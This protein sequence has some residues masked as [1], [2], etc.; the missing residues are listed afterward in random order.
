MWIVSVRVYVI[1]SWLDRWTWVDLAAESKSIIS[2]SDD[3][4]SSES[5]IREDE[6]D[7]DFADRRWQW[8]DGLKLFSKRS[9][10][11]VITKVN[12]NQK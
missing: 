3:K 6:S 8:Q 2:L 1:V 10:L 11:S 4:D 9:F 5:E 7:V 12:Q